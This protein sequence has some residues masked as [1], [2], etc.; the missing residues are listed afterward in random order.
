MK[1]N[2]LK[3]KII[4]KRYKDIFFGI[5]YIILGILVI[6]NVSTSTI[7]NV[8][9]SK[10]K[11]NWKKMVKGLIKAIIFYI[12]AA[13]LSVAFTILPYINNM[14]STSFEIELISNEVLEMLSSAG[15]LGTV[16]TAIVTQGKRALTGLLKM[17]EV[18]T[19]EEI[20]W[21]VEE[22]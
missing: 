4:N 15:V 21:N 16:V 1:K 13:A 9:S 18:S 3:E 10:E 12:S 2:N 20:T 7:Y 8:W 19:S 6:V 5:I 22:E 17:Q 14:I 11:F